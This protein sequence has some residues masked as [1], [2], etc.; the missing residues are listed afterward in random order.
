M[1]LYRMI[2]VGRPMHTD[3]LRVYTA[4]DFPK[5]PLPRV[6]LFDVDGT[7]FDT[8]RLWAEALALVFEELGCRQAARRLM[9]LTYGLAWP[10]AYAALR[11]AF[12]E[13]LRGISS[14]ALGHRLCVRFDALFA[15]APPVIEGAVALVRRLHGLGVRCGY[16]SGSP[17]ATSGRNLRSCGL[18]AFLD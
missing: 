1:G 11:T 6:A 18:E 13:V 15:L 2:Q 10:D 8:E 16:V 17:R 9:A 3:G 12:P 5:M 14:G 7:L 4:A